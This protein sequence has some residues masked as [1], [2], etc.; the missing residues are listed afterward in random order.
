MPSE[1]CKP[2]PKHTPDVCPS[3]STRPLRPASSSGTLGIVALD[4]LPRVA[5]DERD[6][7]ELEARRQGLP[8]FRITEIK[9]DGRIGAAGDRD[10][11]FPVYGMYP[12]KYNELALGLDA[13]FAREALFDGARDTG[14]I[15]ASDPIRL[16]GMEDQWGVL[17]VA[18]IYSVRNVASSE[19]RR[20]NLEGY[21]LAVFRVSELFEAI[22]PRTT[23]TSGFDHYIFDGSPD[24]LGALL[25][26]H[27]S[28]LRRADDPPPPLAQVDPSNVHANAVDFH[29]RQWTIMTVPSQA[30]NIG[31]EADTILVLA[32]GLVATG[33]ATFY[34]DFHP[35]AH[36]RS[37]QTDGGAARQ[38]GLA[39]HRL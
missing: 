8:E 7:F 21:A 31:I 30:R 18:P 32:L 22:E 11:Y 13:K 4:Y 14:K 26:V 17:L 9:P 24:H 2:L 33:L 10:E 25:A 34:V 36:R 27:A 29:G 35:A 16:I 15:V 20:A 12:P 37:E 6:A 3:A 28:R 39:S 5:A 19:T 38:G 23:E 1:A